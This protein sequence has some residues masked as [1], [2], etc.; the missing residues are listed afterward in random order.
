MHLQPQ[1]PRGDV[2]QWAEQHDDGDGAGADSGAEHPAQ[3]RE[4][5]E[6]GDLVELTLSLVTDE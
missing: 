2:D 1:H 4:G 3:R 6:V 5:L